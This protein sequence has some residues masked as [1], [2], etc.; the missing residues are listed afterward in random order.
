MLLLVLNAITIL[1]T[2]VLFHLKTSL[3]SIILGRIV[4]GKQGDSVR[5]TCHMKAAGY[6][7][8][9]PKVKCQFECSHPAC[10]GKT[11]NGSCWGRQRGLFVCSNARCQI[12]HWKEIM[13]LSQKS[14]LLK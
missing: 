11:T 6:E 12:K 3:D 8:V 10:M 7:T 14:K 2:K 4:S 9:S 5:R 13:A 1:I